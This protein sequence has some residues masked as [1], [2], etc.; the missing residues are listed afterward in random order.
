M[1]IENSMNVCLQY[2]FASLYIVQSTHTILCRTSHLSVTCVSVYALCLGE[3]FQTGSSKLHIT[4]TANLRAF[5]V[6]IVHQYWICT[7]W[8]F[9]SIL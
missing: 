2:F 3:S 1:V 7:F 4:V 5:T 8:M 9:I 6:K